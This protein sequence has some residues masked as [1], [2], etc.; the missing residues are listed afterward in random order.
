MTE[1]GPHEGAVFPIGLSEL[2]GLIDGQQGVGPDVAFR[3]PLW[4]GVPCPAP[5]PRDPGDLEHES[6]PLRTAP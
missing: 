5:A 2:R 1:R 6:V 4:A 3:V